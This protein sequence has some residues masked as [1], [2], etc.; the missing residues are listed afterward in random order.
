MLLRLA[1][2]LGRRWACL[3]LGGLLLLDL[4]IADPLPFVD[5]ALLTVLTA[6]CLRRHSR[7]DAAAEG[8]D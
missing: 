4:V 6:G 2:M 7:E 5:E 8:S 3:A 1:K